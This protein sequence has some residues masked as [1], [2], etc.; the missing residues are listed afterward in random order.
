MQSS[1]KRR[2][3]VSLVCGLPVVCASILAFRYWYFRETEHHS[4]MSPDGRWIVVVT[5]RMHEF[6]GEMEVRLKIIENIEGQPERRLEVLDRT[7]D[8]ADIHKRSYQVRWISKTEFIVG[9]LYS[10]EDD[11]FGWRFN[12]EEWVV[13]FPGPPGSLKIK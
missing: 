5:K 4:V 12:G 6:M 3:I 10:D 1:S 13:R 7:D 8:W 2:W 11:E 9:G